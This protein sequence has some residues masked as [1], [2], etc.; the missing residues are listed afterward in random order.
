MSVRSGVF[1][2]ESLFSLSSL[3]TSVADVSVFSV[4]GSVGVAGL[5]SFLVSST[6]RRTW[7]RE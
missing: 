3:D 6:A 4:S 7:N 1:P 5:I 2:S